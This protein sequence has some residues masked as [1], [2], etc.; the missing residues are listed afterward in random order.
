MLDY[1]RV[2]LAAHDWL[3]AWALSLIILGAAVGLAWLVHRLLFRL[4]SRI[5]AGRALFWR[6]MVQRTR[7]LMLLA[8]L[9][10]AIAIA[11]RV[12]PLEFA[13]ARTLQHLLLIG[14]I[15]LIGWAASTAVH[16]WTIVY[17]RRFKLDAE[18][19]LLA[20]KHATQTRILSRVGYTVIGLFTAAI[21]LMTFDSVRQ[22]GVSLLAAG[23][24][25]GIV[26]GLALQ[27]LLRNLF[28]GI[29]IATT[30]PIRLEDA[31]IV[32]GEWGNVE[33][34]TSTYVVVRLWDLRRMVLPLSYFLEKPFQ[35][36]TRESSSLIGSVML[37]LDYSAPV[38]ALRAR[39]EEVARA[40]CNWDGNV[41]NLQVTD[42][43]EAV[44]EVR[45]LVS[46]S[47]AGR[48]FDLRCE[49]REK[50]VAW[51]QDKHPDA[52]PRRRLEVESLPREAVGAGRALQA[53]RAGE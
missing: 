12:A 34:I 30:Q 50:L 37:Y 27:P 11:S 19:N 8:L 41:V 7:G 42:F 2:G 43:R 6:A 14:L 17:L 47:N 3:P 28:A 40:S 21:A 23:G 16:I 18:D 46:A 52:L 9:G 4:A 10:L 5:V 38:A 15:C 25:A 49:V 20:R 39:L 51:L 44:M 53:A 35:N 45:M 29:Q 22:Y 32:E 48:A 31:V 1:L 26:L 13:W 36:W 33:D 24:A